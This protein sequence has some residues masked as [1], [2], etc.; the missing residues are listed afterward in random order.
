MIGLR[1]S[2][3]LKLL[4][5][6]LG[7]VGLLLV[8][9]YGVVQSVTDQQVEVAADRASETAAGQ[10]RELEEMQQQQVAR[11]ARPLTEGRRTLAALD[12]AVQAGDRSVLTDLAVYEL[13][14]AAL[15]DVMVAFTDARGQA[16]LT[17][18]DD[19]A[20]E[21]ADPLRIEPLADAL[22]AGGSA[23]RRGYRV[24]GDRLYAV[25]M[26]LIQLAGRTI[27]TLTIGL[28]VED[29]NVESIG[30]AL[31]IQ[32]CVVVE[33]ACV[34][35]TPQAR[36]SLSDALVSLAGIANAQRL[37]AAGEAWSVRS[38]Q[39]VAGDPAQGIRVVAVPLAEITAPFR[40][41]T[42]A[43]L[44]G[45]LL[46]LSVAT[47]LALILSRG[48]TRPVH[49]LVAATGRVAAGDY[50]TEVNIPSRD[51]IGRLAGAF[52]DMTRGLLLKE[53][54]RSVLDKVVSRDVA[55]QLLGGSVEL[56]G[57]NRH[58]SVL[59]GDIRGFT[60]LTEGMEP[61]AVIALLNACM[62]RLSDAVDQEGGVVDKFVGDEI[63][64][65]FGAPVRQDDHAGRAVRAALRMR[66]ALTELNR[67]R[68]A[69]G[70]PALGLGV[71]INSGDAVAGNMGSKNRLN[72]TV[73]GHMV[74]LAS[75]LC[76]GAA[77]GE[78]L[79]TR[80]T[81]LDAGPGF[82]VRPLGPRAY[83]GFSSEVDVFALQEE[84]AVSTDG[85]GDL[86]EPPVA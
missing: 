45:G 52:N 20:M 86:A 2:F 7:T 32:V 85:D 28:P 64:A 33:G 5:A 39:L 83:K 50:E 24:L 43:L 1:E 80:T 76:T 68:S 6:L 53:Q 15:T 27:G 79:L 48:L 81:L 8:I 72:Y 42:R 25:R 26:R 56:G 62:Q 78:I 58:V 9:T 47:L 34:A 49:A 51:E 71:G 35:G 60:T 38:Q 75:R 74:N 69:R 63:M 10:F 14:L 59:F 54:Y 22:L 46:A 4:A 44:L 41:I 70:E 12:A 21:G 13:D 18:H 66:E 82:R 36:S 16:V 30:A 23:E 73:L 65:V 55:E 84:E 67:D 77:A 3:R 61:Q 29:A 17:L 19:E 11:V 40:L 37:D 31:G 57:E